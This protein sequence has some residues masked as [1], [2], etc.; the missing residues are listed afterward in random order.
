VSRT[1]AEESSD[2]TAQRV[3][4]RGHGG[5]VTVDDVIDVPDHTAGG[6]RRVVDDGGAGRTGP[7]KSIIAASPSRDCSCCV[8]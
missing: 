8:Q 1:P 4:A 2:P 3:L 6:K 5:F 7:G